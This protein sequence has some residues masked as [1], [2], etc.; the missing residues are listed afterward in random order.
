MR[1]GRRRDRRAPRRRTRQTVRS[2][3]T[4]VARE[5][6]EGFQ[7]GRAQRRRI[8]KEPGFVQLVAFPELVSA[9]AQPLRRVHGRFG[10]EDERPFGGRRGLALALAT[11]RISSLRILSAAARSARTA[12]GRGVRRNRPIG[13][14]RGWGADSWLRLPVLRI[15]RSYR[16]RRASPRIRASRLTSISNRSA[17]PSRKCR[18]GSISL[19]GFA[20]PSEWSFW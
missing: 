3:T 14:F 11:V 4:I 9:N 20:C 8:I 19:G 6:L 17:R 12:I 15:G 16:E 1:E 10:I 7:F 2:F 18:M 5:A 13:S